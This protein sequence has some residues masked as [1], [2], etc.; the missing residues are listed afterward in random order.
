M[1]LSG[2]AGH[3][4]VELLRL[5]RWVSVLSQRWNSHVGFIGLSSPEPPN[6]LGLQS[7][8]LAAWE[9]FAG[10]KSC[11]TRSSPCPC[12]DLEVG[13]PALLR[14]GL[15]GCPAKRC[16]SSYLILLPGCRAGG[17]GG[18]GGAADLALSGTSVSPARG[19]DTWQGFSRV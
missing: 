18:Q 1:W 2:P 12:S 15:P 7:S 5:K 10:S 11:T 17:R 9:H 3:E 16:L 19:C 13:S 4:D 14:Q 8:P 6:P